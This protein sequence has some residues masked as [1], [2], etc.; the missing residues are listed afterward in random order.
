MLFTS[1]SKVHQIEKEI[2]VARCKGRWQAIP[3][4]ARRYVKH[5]P[6]GK[7]MVEKD[8]KQRAPFE[9]HAHSS[10]LTAHSSIY[11]FC[12]SCHLVAMEHLLLAES[13]LVRL[14]QAKKPWDSKQV[15]TIQNQLHLVIDSNDTAMDTLKEVMYTFTCIVI[16]RTTL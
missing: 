1:A 9:W 7:G 14:G 5:N 12:L 15:L 3:D 4:L 2:D 13:A 16:S 8:S 11:L 10:I 6:K